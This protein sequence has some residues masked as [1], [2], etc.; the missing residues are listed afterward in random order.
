LFPHWNWAGREGESIPVWVHSN[1]DAVELLFNGRSL[2]RKKVKTGRHLEWKVRYKPGTLMARGWKAGKLVATRKVETTGAPAGIRL[3]ADRRVLRSDGEDTT[4]VNVAVVD[5]RGRVVP[6]ADNLVGFAVAG[7]G[8]ILGVGNGDPSSH[9]PDQAVQR[10][11]FNGWCQVVVQAGRSAGSLQ[12]T[13]QSSGLTT[14]KLRLTVKR[15]TPRP[16]VNGMQGSL[17]RKFECSMLQRAPANIAQAPAVKASLLFS[18]VSTVVPETAF[19]DVRNFHAGKHGLLYIRTS[20]QMETGGAGRLLYGVD[21]PVRVW[22]NGQAVDC[23][24]N[25]SNPAIEGQYGV[26]VRWRKGVNDICF[27]LVTQHGRAWGV[28]ARMVMP[29][30]QK[31]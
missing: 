7:R 8:R 11:V 24:P 31:S 27:G 16:T 19:C 14:A 29:S 22:V 3:I 2:G 1:C 20:C 15:A 5:A 10:R 28:F 30:G 4:V 18:P 17:L 12:L 26:P 21:G 25:A 9:E 13:A 6:V 23:R